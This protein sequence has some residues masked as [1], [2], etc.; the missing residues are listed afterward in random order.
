MTNRK[1]FK[2]AISIYSMVKIVRT[3]YDWGLLGTPVVSLSEGNTDTIAADHPDINEVAVISPFDPESL[4]LEHGI[5][6]GNPGP[7]YAVWKGPKRPNP[8][9]VDEMSF[10]DFLSRFG[11]E[12]TNGR[13]WHYQLETHGEPVSEEP[14]K[15]MGFG[16]NAYGKSPLRSVD[17][18]RI[19]VDPANAEEVIGSSLSF[20]LGEGLHYAVK[21]DLDSKGT[22]RM[23]QLGDVVAREISGGFTF[24]QKEHSMS[25]SWGDRQDHS[26]YTISLETEN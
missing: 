21:V 11:P 20:T 6:F 24:T 13:V 8:I 22:V 14:S 12:A 26:V 7:T 25:S 4:Y 10:R 19:V 3:N 15:Y 9:F 1:V 16:P 17:L 18:E 23:Y 2:L 5:E